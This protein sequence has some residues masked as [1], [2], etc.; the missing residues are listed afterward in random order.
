MI[1]ALE[2]STRHASLA[3]CDPVSEQVIAE[4]AFTTERAHNAAIFGPLSSLVEQHRSSLRGFVVGLGPG[5]YGGVRVGLA[6]ANGL[7]VAMNLP[8][9]GRSSLEAW[10]TEEETYLVIGDARRGSFFIAEIRDRLLQGDPI[11]VEESDLPDR[12]APFLDRGLKIHSSDP[13]ALEIIPETCLSFPRARF[14]LSNLSEEDLVTRAST[15][16]EPHYLRA[17]YITTPKTKA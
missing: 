10:E 13:K 4:A 5:S 6:V 12:L 7:S 3:V 17:P 16:L 15:S 14:L 2:T 8:V 9:V 11:L 1:L